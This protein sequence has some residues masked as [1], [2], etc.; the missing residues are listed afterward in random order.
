M[1][2]SEVFDDLT[3]RNDSSFTN[4]MYPME[5]AIPITVVYAI[6]FIAGL[7]GNISTCIV[8][9]RNKS[10]HTATNYYLF[11]LAISDLLLLI[12]GLPPEMYRIWSPNEYIFGQA[13]CVIQGFAAETSANA[14]VLTITAFTVERY[15]AICHPF[16]SQTIAKLSRIIKFIVA[17][18]LVALSLA[19]PQAMQFGVQYE[20]DGTSGCSVVQEGLFQHSFE[21]S[22]FVFF[23]GPMTLITVL[24]VL[25]AIKLRKSRLLLSTQHSTSDGHNHRRITRSNKSSAGQKKVIK[26]LVA[27]VTAF[28][29]CWAPFHAQRLFA[30]YLANA[31]PE[32]QEI[33][34]NAYVALI[35]I[36]GVLYF[37]STTVNPLLYNIMSNKFRDAFKTTLAQLCKTR[38][39]RELNRSY[40]V[41][42]KYHPSRNY[43]RSVSDGAASTATTEI[44]IDKIGSKSKSAP[45]SR[46]HSTTNF[47]PRLLTPTNQT[48]V[49]TNLIK[50]DTKSTVENALLPVPKLRQNCQKKMRQ[51]KIEKMNFWRRCTALFKGT[52]KSDTFKI[53]NNSPD[54]GNTISNSSLQDMDEMEFSSSDLVKYMEE[55]NEDIT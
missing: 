18:W 39:E 53:D 49:F 47:R 38:R 33:A 8:I 40:S 15:V 21:I 28:F 50:S 14:T 27:V 52:R 29:V 1:N 54:M 16:L 31:T 51:R 44:R 45:N 4:N 24:Y 25:I 22:A 34:F 10:M 2:E 41:L 23:M 42:S 12:S 17:I 13:F 19:I 26:M 46:Q 55:V 43:Q 48:T 32:Q 37:L 5:W 35:H 36:S 11:S 20:S 7:L 30:I 3:P 6:I 9:S